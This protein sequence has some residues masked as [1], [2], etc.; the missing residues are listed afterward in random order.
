MTALAGLR[1]CLER[2]VLAYSVEKLISCSW[3]IL[4]VNHFA[5][6]NQQ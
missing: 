1:S 2:P 6:W 4:Q 5:A 3:G